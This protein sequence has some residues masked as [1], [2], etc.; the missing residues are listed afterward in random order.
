VPAQ[1]TEAPPAPAPRPRYEPLRWCSRC[2]RLRGESSFNRHKGGLQWW[3]RDCF[4]GYYEEQRDRHRR[5]NNALKTARVQEAQAFVLEYLRR[6]ACVDCGQT[7]PVVL[8][9]DHLNEK[10]AEISTLVRRGVLRA[11][12]ER[13]IARCEVVCASC[14]RR[15]TARRGGWRRLG[16]E[17]GA[18]RSKA[19]ERNVRFALDV[20]VESGCVDCGESDVC[21]LD[22]DHVGHKTGGV[23]QLAHREVGLRRLREEIAR[24]VVRCANCHRRRTACERGH[25]RARAVI[26]PARVELALPD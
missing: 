18:W 24:C 9:F 11:V 8:D 13:E 21:V 25:Y 1:L 26:P 5:R 10:R 22:F 2:S 15:R 3:C 6:H 17:S 7:D 16:A 20:L 23:M 14:H 4:K 12:L 19:Q